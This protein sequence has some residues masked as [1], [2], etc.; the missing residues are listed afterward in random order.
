MFLGRPHEQKKHILIYQE[1]GE[2][3][4]GEME[5][6]SEITQMNLASNQLR[7]CSEESCRT[8]RHKNDGGTGDEARV[9][10]HKAIRV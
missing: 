6:S 1:L 4:E 2:K 5:N 10:C 3:V 9:L 8:T 7:L